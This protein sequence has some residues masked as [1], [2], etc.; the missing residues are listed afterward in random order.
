M[1]QLAANLN[2]N[3]AKSLRIQRLRRARRILEIAIADLAENE[4]P[5]C[6]SWTNRL[7][8]MVDKIIGEVEWSGVGAKRWQSYIHIA[9]TSLKASKRQQP[10]PT[11]S[12]WTLQATRKK[13]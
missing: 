6:Y 5:D 1:T 2:P 9:K 7:M 3:E 10:R 13:S 11:K 4:D 8:P 12:L